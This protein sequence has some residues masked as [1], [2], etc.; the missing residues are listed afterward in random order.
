VRPLVRKKTL[1]YLET[2]APSRH[3]EKLRKAQ[4][5]DHHHGSNGAD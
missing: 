2:R 4:E 5:L 3:R 1:R